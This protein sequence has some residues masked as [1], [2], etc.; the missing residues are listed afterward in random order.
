MLR[1]LVV[2]AIHGGAIRAWNEV[3]VGVDG[4]LNRRVPHLLVHA[5]DRLPLLQRQRRERV[6]KVVNSDLSGFGSP[7]QPGEEMPHVAFFG[8]GS[9]Q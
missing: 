9:C 4:D 2:Q 7:E 1:R 8:R 6:S 3:A 5:G